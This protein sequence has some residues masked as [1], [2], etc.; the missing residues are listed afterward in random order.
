MYPFNLFTSRNQH[1]VFWQIPAVNIITSSSS[2]KI[3]SYSREIYHSLWVVHEAPSESLQSILEETY[4]TTLSASQ[5][6][7]NFSPKLPGCAVQNDSPRLFWFWNCWWRRS[8]LFS[9]YHHS[10][11]IV[12]SEHSN[13]TQNLS[14]RTW[15]I[16]LRLS[17]SWVSPRCMSSSMIMWSITICKVLTHMALHRHMKIVTKWHHVVSQRMDLCLEVP[18]TNKIHFYQ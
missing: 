18:S 3:W 4:S 14:Q 15:M 1:K 6:S 10:I 12:S 8:P 17:S 16:L 7:S 11:L 5:E 9:A 13:C 2:F